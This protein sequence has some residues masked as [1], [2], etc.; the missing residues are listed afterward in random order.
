MRRRILNSRNGRTS[1]TVARCLLYPQANFDRKA[2]A[3]RW[4]A[5]GGDEQQLF[6]M[7]SA[8]RNKETAEQ[9]LRSVR[10]RKSIQ[11]PQ[12]GITPRRAGSIGSERVNILSA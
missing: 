2:P 1:F 3:D 6:R 12:H 11:Q 9:A 8:E 10:S 5:Y 7:M 4:A